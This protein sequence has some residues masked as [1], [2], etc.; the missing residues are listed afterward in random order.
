MLSSVTDVKSARAQVEE[1]Q[2]EVERMAELEANDSPEFDPESY[3]DQ[4]EYVT[5]A[6]RDLFASVL[7]AIAAGAENAVEL[8]RVALGEQD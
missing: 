5:E 2:A 6:E 4:R 1:A 8:A 3:Y 7:M